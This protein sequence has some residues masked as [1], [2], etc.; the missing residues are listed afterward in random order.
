M[1]NQ[2]FAKNF[3][4]ISWGMIFHILLGSPILS[5]GQVTP[6][7]GFSNCPSPLQELDKDYNNIDLIIFLS[8]ETQRVQNGKA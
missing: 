6:V 8:D 4:L 5:E 7:S 1:L 3:M 2:S